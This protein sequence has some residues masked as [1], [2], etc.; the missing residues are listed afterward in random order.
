MFKIVVFLS[1]LVSHGM[2]YSMFES[3]RAIN[4]R[5]Y[6]LIHAI[7][8]VVISTQKTRGLT[9]NYMNGNVVAQLL[10]YGQRKQ[11]LDNF[12]TIDKSFK[13]LELSSQYYEDASALML[14][15]KFLNKSAFKSDSSRVFASYSGVIEKW[16]ELNAKVIK[17]RFIDADETVYKDL[18]FLNQ[19]LLPLSENIGKMRGLGSGLVAKGYCNKKEAKTMEGFVSEIQ[20]YAMLLKYHMSARRH[21][22]MGFSEV[23]SIHKSIKDYMELTKRK[24]IGQYEIELVTNEYFDQG[25]DNISKI[26]KIY[27]IISSAL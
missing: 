12:E 26:L 27:N 17:A 11:M 2:A 6:K 23:K 8:D 10:V 14:R 9:N 25:T 22:N 13:E 7:K 19:V 24:V 18:N 16:M 15:S 21:E 4:E 5:H 1:L 20:R 3:E